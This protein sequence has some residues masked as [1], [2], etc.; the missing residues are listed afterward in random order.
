[1]MLLLGAVEMSGFK[2]VVANRE[3][4]ALHGYDPVAYF[5]EGRPLIGSPVISAEHGELTWHFSNSVHRELF[6]GDPA[7]YIPKYGGYCG[8][9]ISVGNHTEFDPDI[10]VI[11][12]G[13]LYLF[14]SQ[15]ARE[16]WLA[17]PAKYRTFADQHYS[18]LV[19][20]PGQPAV[21]FVLTSHDEL[22]D[23]GQRTG[24][25]LSEISHPHQVL[26]EAGYRI[27][28]ASPQGGPAP[29]DPKSLD[30]NDPVNAAFLADKAVQFKMENTAP[31]DSIDPASFLGVFFP[32]GHG[33]MFDLPNNAHIPTL[34]TRIH[35]SGGVV[36]AVCHGPA[37]LVNIR[38]ENG[39][40][41]VTGRTLAAFTDQEEAAVDLT[42]VMPFL[43]ESTL[44]ERGARVAKAPNFQPM[45]QSEDRV[46]T[47][48]NPASA[49]GVG[50]AMVEALNVAR[51]QADV[52]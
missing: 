4:V 33:A 27:V 31:L 2:S 39:E 45:V 50:R 7:R 40:Y 35:G 15:D 19:A 47:G 13:E 6:L 52:R 11:Q 44:L 34:V 29:I 9:C 25:Y 10:W 28:F 32:G 36:G 17:E 14:A 38:D 5:E 23:T 26:S 49:I 30:E 43:L 46:V 18:N 20:N 51:L 24:A 22:G 12:D 16:A 37:A 8:I 42:D 1:M 41:F 21:L 48:Q 3:D